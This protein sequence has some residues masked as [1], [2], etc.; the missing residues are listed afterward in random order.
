MICKN[1]NHVL[2]VAQ[3]VVN[4]CCCKEN[5]LFPFTDVSQFPIMRLTLNPWISEVMRLVD[6]DGV[7]GGRD[8]AE[9][10]GE[11]AAAAGCSEFRAPPSGV[12]PPPLFH[13][14]RL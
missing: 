11:V 14:R 1:L 3:A 13:A 6:H 10:F 7:G 9:P 8:A 5:Y 12:L 2:Q 4:G